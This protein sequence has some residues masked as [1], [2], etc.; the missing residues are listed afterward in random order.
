MEIRPYGT[1]MENQHGP[2]DVVKIELLSRLGALG[3]FG[4][5]FIQQSAD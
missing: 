3:E 4:I 1:I 2:A 5:H